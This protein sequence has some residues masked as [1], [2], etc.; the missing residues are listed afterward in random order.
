MFFWKKLEREGVTKQ[1]V[2]NRSIL[3][4]SSASTFSPIES[5]VRII[6]TWSSHPT[7]PPVKNYFWVLA[8]VIS[9]V[10][11]Y[12][13]L[14]NYT[15]PILYWRK[16]LLYYTIPIPIL[17]QFLGG[18]VH[19]FM[20]SAWDKPLQKCKGNQNFV[21]SSPSLWPPTP[22]LHSTLHQPLNTVALLLKNEGRGWGAK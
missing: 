12:Q 14:A 11:L 4:P 2:K 9:K 18:F 1:I 5:W 10:G 22:P 13:V 7:H 15:I 3:L 8:I 21:M 20:F 17:Y 6:P 19:G 16:Q